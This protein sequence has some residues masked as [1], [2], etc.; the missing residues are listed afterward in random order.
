VSG[1]ALAALAV[2]GVLWATGAA[3]GAVFGVLA[4][5]AG[6]AL[7]VALS[8][9]LISANRLRYQDA[10]FPA[11]PPF[12]AAPAGGAGPRRRSTG[13]RSGLAYVCMVIFG[14][15]ITLA[16]LAG[17]N[18]Q[19]RALSLVWLVLAACCVSGCYLA[20]PAA[21]F[22]VTPQ[23]LHIDTALRRVTVP[24]YLIAG[25]ERGPRTLTLHSHGGDHVDIRVDSPLWDIRGGEYRTNIRAQL[26]VAERIVAMMREV[27]AA[28]DGGRVVSTGRRGMRIL[29]IAT[30]AVAV[31]SIVAFPFAVKAGS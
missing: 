20:G 31:A 23:Y 1:G 26:R 17:W 22:V 15:G 19:G 5:L 7:F 3:G 14:G 30:A 6:V 13:R 28:A 9:R 12:S 2:G 27:P 8:G 21:R 10:E 4:P 24:R 18:T 11:V 16:T 29:A 25:F